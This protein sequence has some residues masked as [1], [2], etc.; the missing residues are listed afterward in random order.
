[1]LRMLRKCIFWVFLFFDQMS[2]EQNWKQND[3]H[4]QNCK[5]ESREIKLLSDCILAR[6]AA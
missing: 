1:M 4:T 3:V 6:H 2:Q 5:I